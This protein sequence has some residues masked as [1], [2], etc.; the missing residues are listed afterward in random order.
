LREFYAGDNEWVNVG[1]SAIVDP[2][3]NFIAGPVRLKVEI[4]YADIDVV[5]AAAAKFEF[6]AAGHYARPDV[7][8]LRVNRQARPMI[9]DATAPSAPR[10]NE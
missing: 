5:Q 2:L 9:E 1:D 3:G 6:D 4:L 8:Q 10:E 7:F